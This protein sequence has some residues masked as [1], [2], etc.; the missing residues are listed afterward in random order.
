MRTDIVPAHEPVQHEL[1]PGDVGIEG[2]PP[3]L[4]GV[5]AANTEAEVTGAYR[6]A[7]QPADRDGRIV[8]QHQEVVQH[9]TWPKLDPRP[10]DLP[11]YGVEGARRPPCLLAEELGPR[12]GTLTDRNQVGGVDRPPVP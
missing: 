5:Q 12:C 8:G 10:P 3:A 2:K 6:D 11:E 4:I 7:K 9:R 1:Q